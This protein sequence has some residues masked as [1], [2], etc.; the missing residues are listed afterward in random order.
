MQ[1]PAIVLPWRQYL[2]AVGC[3]TLPFAYWLLQR[4]AKLLLPP[5]LLSQAGESRYTVVL[6]LL[7]R[8]LGEGD[9]E[10]G[11]LQLLG[12]LGHHVAADAAGSTCF[13]ERFERLQSNPMQHVLVVEDREAKRLCASGTLLVEP[14]FIHAAGIVGHLEDIVTQPA[15]RGKGIGSRV[16]RSLLQRARESGAYKCILDCEEHNVPFYKDIGFREKEDQYVSNFEANDGRKPLLSLEQSD[17]AFKRLV[18]EERDVGNGLIVRQLT[19]ADYDRSYLQLLAQ[20]TTVGDLSK[21]KFCDRLR[22]LRQLGSYLTFVMH[23]TASDKVVASATVFVETKFAHGCGRCAHIEDVV[24]D[25]NV[26]GRGLGNII[27][28]AARDAAE[29][30]GCYQCV[31]DC[32]E[33]NGPFYRKCGFDKRGVCMALYFDR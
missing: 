1:P 30:V 4:A 12:L 10:K 6:R 33:S 17:A 27:V 7:Q 21:E 5:W 19:E 14:K 22:M 8:E 32:K 13:A 15:L 20:L 3:M 31:L 23:D 2:V 29:A 26:R 16:V 24:V 25:N 9:G 11:F 28:S 18:C